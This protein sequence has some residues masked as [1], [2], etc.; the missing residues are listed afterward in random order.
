MDETDREILEILKED[1][2]ASFT[3]IAS[4]VG[5]SEGT[6]RNRVNGMVD[7][8][9][10]ERFT[11][12]TRQEGVSAVV[13]LVV[14]TEVDIEQILDSLPT[15]I[16]VY[17]VTGE[18]DLVIKM[19]RGSSGELNETLDSMR[20]VRGVEKTKTYSILQSHYR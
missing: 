12:Q 18:Y 14:S 8:G 16:E 4:E 2:R 17:E 19:S 9:V 15:D 13:M 11:V 6:V 20:E 5:V 3:R 1:G 7:D 10:I